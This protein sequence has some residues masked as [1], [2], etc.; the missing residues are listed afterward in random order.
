[1]SNHKR[2]S[3][4]QDPIVR[5]L[6]VNNPV[7]WDE[8]VDPL[9]L[10]NDLI[11]TIRRYVVLDRAYAVAVALWV[12]QA[13]AI[14][15]VTIMPLL[16]ITAPERGSGK[17]V[18][19]ELIGKLVP[20]PLVSS[21]ISMAALFRIVDAHQPTLLLD[22]ADVLFQGNT[23]LTGLLNDGYRQG[24]HVFRVD[25]SQ[26]DYRVVGFKVF[27][28]KALA[29]IALEHRLSDATIS[30]AF[31]IAMRRR[32]R[33]EKFERLRHADS[34]EFK[35]LRSRIAWLV[36]TNAH[37][38]AMG[39]RELP[40]EL[41]DRDQ[42]N[43]QYAW[44]IAAL[45]GDEGLDIVRNAVQWIGEET[46]A[47]ESVANRLLRDV[48]LVLKR[49]RESRIPTRNL[50]HELNSLED[51]DWNRF[52][53]GREL[54]SRQLASYLRSYGLRPRTVRMPTGET[55]KGYVVAEFHEAFER[56]L[57]PEEPEEE[58][59]LR[60]PRPEPVDRC[61]EG[62]LLGDETEEAEGGLVLPAGLS[63]DDF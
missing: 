54:T 27:S 4:L 52:N 28:A 18:L 60:P 49:Y 31:V 45:A 16:V 14:E 19:L 62:Q 26:D 9:Q 63:E 32:L 61:T 21:N 34:T 38:M 3:M 20:R 22:E 5:M 35:Q 8:P 48:R 39:Y 59:V 7:P 13:W 33:D 24:G 10:M 23:D 58:A 51:A 42:D 44:A 57:P 6:A 43:W 55:P 36:K 11:A 17:S 29:G 15:H 53:Y 50:L 12:I 41:G 47:P 56:Y 1:M 25:T 2:K 46:D 37:E 30:R 40:D